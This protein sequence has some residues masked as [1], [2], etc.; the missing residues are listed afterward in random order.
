MAEMAIGYGS[1]YQLLRCLGHHRQALN[2]LIK[3]ETGSESTID[4]F[5]YPI[6]LNRDS[7]DGELK[8]IECFKKQISPNRYKAIHK[9]WT[10]FWPGRGNAMNW[11]GIFIQNGV[12]YFVE[13]KANALE[14]YQE[15]GASSSI[16]RNKI[17]AAFRTTQNSF[18]FP[19]NENWINSSC[20][21]LANRLAFLYFC[22]SQGIEAKLL[23]IGF[24]N[25]CGKKSVTSKDD[26]IRI[27]ND[28]FS[29]LG[30]PPEKVSD[31]VLHIHPNCET[32][33]LR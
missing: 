32:A 27:W 24:V 17:K 5:D 18:G 20:Y 12:W 19:E 22:R 13:A 15:C 6:D 11:D 33:D 26:W 10:A 3:E 8:G 29:I 21:Q 2:V 23:Y 25:G 9:A 30:I 1:E 7:L 31:L 4:W 28:E 14:A 16:S